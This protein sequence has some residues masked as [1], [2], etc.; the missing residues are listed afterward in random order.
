MSVPQLLQSNE[1]KRIGDIIGDSFSDD[2]VN[3]WVFGDDQ[4]HM[5][6]QYA[7]NAKKL[8]LVQG[9][10]HVMPDNTGGTLWLPPGV[11]KEIP[12]WNSLDIAAAMIR[13]G[14][15]SSLMSGMAIDAHLHKKHPKEP[16]YYLFAIGAIQ[17]CQGQ[18]IGKKLMRAGLAKADKDGMPA[19][20]ESSKEVNVSFYRRFGFEVIEKTKP[21]KGCPPLWL[22]WRDARDV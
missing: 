18:G 16:H 21:P 14:G 12:L 1:F 10:G 15:F 11:K 8:Y 3:R 6:Y 2:P 5:A 22:M 19:Y 20:L 9:F 17:G 4:G 7:L 13:H